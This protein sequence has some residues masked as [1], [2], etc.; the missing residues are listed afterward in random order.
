MNIFLDTCILFKDPYFLKNYNKEFLELV[1]KKKINLFISNVVVQELERNYGKTIDDNN[2]SLN[3]IISK[4]KDYLFVD[5]PII[6]I[7]KENSI[8]NLGNYYGKL[9]DDGFLTLLFSD[10]DLL[11]EIIKRSVKRLKPFSENKT[12]LK[13]TIIWL[14]YSRYVEKNDIKDCIFLTDNVSDFCDMEKNKQG[15]V[16]IHDELKK[17]SNRFKVYRNTTELL[18]S[19]SKKLQSLS[20][21]FSYWLSNQNIDGEFVLDLI[22]NK[23]LSIIESNVDHYVESKDLNQVFC[24]NENISGTIFVK[25]LFLERCNEITVDT[26]EDKCLISGYLY[27]NVSVDGYVRSIRKDTTDMEFTEYGSTDISVRVVFSFF[28]NS[29]EIPTEFG[30]DSIEIM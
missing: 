2:K 6:E 20:E 12:E 30:I 5:S 1:K 28:Y 19:E 13:D 18:R 11:P 29:S 15:I 16:E 14:T 25:S 23:F 21:R 9:E 10:N 22:E 17:D 7:D 27:L 8:K 26:F 3:Q 24:S 4:G